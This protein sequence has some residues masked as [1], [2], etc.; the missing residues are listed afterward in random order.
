MNAEKTGALITYER[1]KRHISQLALA[2]YLGI[3]PAT[4]RK[5]ERGDK[6]PDEKVMEKLDHLFGAD[7]FNGC[8]EETNGR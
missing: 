3:D 7:K 4:L 1:C 8:R 5:I 6:L 2:A